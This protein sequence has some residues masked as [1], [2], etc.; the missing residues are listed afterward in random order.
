MKYQDTQNAIARKRTLREI[1][2]HLFVSDNIAFRGL[3]GQSNRGEKITG[4]VWFQVDCFII[5]VGANC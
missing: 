5:V 1:E 2:A 4:V 3:G